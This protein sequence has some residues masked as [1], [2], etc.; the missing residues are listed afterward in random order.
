MHACMLLYNNNNNNEMHALLFESVH[1]V[2][3]GMRTVIYAKLES[4][5]VMAQRTTNFSEPHNKL[6]NV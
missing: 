5:F 1:R 4:L 2:L 3:T 6:S